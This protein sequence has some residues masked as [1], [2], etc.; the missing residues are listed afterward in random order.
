MNC[1]N[2]FACEYH[3]LKHFERSLNRSI[4]TNTFSSL[5][6]H[7]LTT[8]SYFHANVSRLDSIIAIT[9]DFAYLLLLDSENLTDYIE[10]FHK[11]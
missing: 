1:E 2:Q 11:K 3:N 8:N 4:N 10:K 7:S 9:H 5:N 6:F